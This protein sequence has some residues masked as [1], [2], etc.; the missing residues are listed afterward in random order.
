MHLIIQWREQLEEEQLQARL[1]V[2][3]ATFEPDRLEDSWTDDSES[4]SDARGGGYQEGSPENL[5]HGADQGG[6]S[7]HLWSALRVVILARCL[8]PREAVGLAM[9][10]HAGR[11]LATG[12]RGNHYPIQD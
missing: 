11:R 2:E 5:E 9:L 3:K 6:L 7:E 4:W 8:R 12:K 1:A 10:S